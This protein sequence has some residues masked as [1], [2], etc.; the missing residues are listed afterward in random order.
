MSIG[1]FHLRAVACSVAVSKPCG[2]KKAE[3]QNEVGGPPAAQRRKK[4]M[5]RRRSSTQPFSG[6]S[7]GYAARANTSGTWKLQ[8]I[9]TQHRNKLPRWNRLGL[10]SRRKE[11]LKKKVEALLHHNS[12][13]MPCLLRWIEVISARLDRQLPRCGMEQAPLSTSRKSSSKEV[14]AFVAPYTRLYVSESPT[15]I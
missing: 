4:S 11:M 8:N 2:K 12:S 7:E 14:A 6:R 10:M 13:N 5:R 9:G 3:S 1:V 15:G